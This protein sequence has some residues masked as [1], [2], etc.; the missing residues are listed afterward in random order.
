MKGQL[1]TPEPGLLLTCFKAL[2]QGLHSCQQ[3]EGLRNP[4]DG[5][6]SCPQVSVLQ[7]PASQDKGGCHGELWDICSGCSKQKFTVFAFPDGEKNGISPGKQ[8]SPRASAGQG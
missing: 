1:P 7:L 2:P 4:G 3:R 8:S 5:S 6:K